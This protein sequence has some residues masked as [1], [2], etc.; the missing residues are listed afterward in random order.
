MKI[1]IYF[2][3]S[4]LIL[5]TIIP[6]YS[7]LQNIDNI[8]VKVLN[9]KRIESQTSDVLFLELSIINNGNSAS[10]VLTNTLFLVDSKSREYASTSYLELKDKGHQINSKD[11]PFVFSLNANPGI[12]VKGNVCYEIPKESSSP[13]SLKLYESTPEICAEPIFD[14]TIKTYPFEIKSDTNIGKISQAKI[15]EWVKNTMKWF[16]EGKVSEDEMINALQFL[17]TQGIIKV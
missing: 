7:Q 10:M 9:V 3:I 5:I 4:G 12:S 2:I 13:Y 17:I 11:C 8:D 6:S 15:P 1:F 14:C 16:I